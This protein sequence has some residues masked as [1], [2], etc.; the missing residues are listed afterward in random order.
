MIL[1]G[2]GRYPRQQCA[3][4]TPRSEAEL[5]ALVRKGSLIARGNGR[6]YG[7]SA[8]N[9]A[10]TVDMRRFNHMLAF[11]PV[12]GQLVV[13][14]GVLL[15]EVIDCFLP[16]GWFPFVTPG[17]KLV[18]IGGMVAA[19]VHGKNHHRDGSF[20]AFVDWLDLLCGDGE[21]RRCS[22]TQEAERFAWTLGGMGLTGVVLRV[23]FRLRRVESGWMRQITL[24]APDLATAMQLFEEHANASYSVAWLDCLAAGNRLGRSVIMLGEHAAVAEL[25][26]D[27]RAAP[28]RT[29]RRKTRTV[30]FNAPSATLNRFTIK[31]FNA[32]YYHRN[33]RRGAQLVDWDSYFYPLDALANWNRIYGARGFLQFQCALPLTSAHAGLMELLRI[34]TRNGQGSFLAV[35]KRLG[36]AREGSLSFPLEGYTLAL[37][38]PVSV[39]TLAL[40]ETLDAVTVAH[41]GRFYLAKDARMR[42]ETLRASDPRV[43]HFFAA[44]QQLGASPFQSSQSERLKL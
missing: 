4:S 40:M 38:F 17:T 14:A 32:A 22:P 19:D 41:G 27:L 28:F 29:P 30:P 21:V 24:P 36:A 8:Q 2:W 1:S 43:P 12:S 9:P 25:P 35:L 26:D 3:L 37:D 34:V 18:T 10:G 31:A 6:S 33:A 23:A 5:R 39:R 42:A 13:E 20:G 15:N 44:R 11:D 16:R 7:D